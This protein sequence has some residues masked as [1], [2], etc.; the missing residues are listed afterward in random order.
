MVGM[1]IQERA[2]LLLAAPTADD[3]IDMFCF[4]GSAA[5]RCV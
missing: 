1:I 3:L 2:G 4:T 5:L